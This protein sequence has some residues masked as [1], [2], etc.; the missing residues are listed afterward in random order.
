MDLDAFDWLLTDPGQLVLARAVALG[1]ETG[2]DPLKAQSALRREFADVEAS[3]V[4]VAMSQASL[5][6]RA[7]AKFGDLAASM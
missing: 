2:G 1:T 3:Y 7:V 5:R 6:A 4:A